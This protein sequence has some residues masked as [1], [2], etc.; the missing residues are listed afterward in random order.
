MFQTT[1]S[2]IVWAKVATNRIWI[3]YSNLKFSEDG[4]KIIIH[5]YEVTGT[6]LIVDAVTGNLF[7]S[8]TYS[9][10]FYNVD[11]EYQ[12]LLLSS[13]YKAFVYSLSKSSFISCG[14]HQLFS[15][16]ANSILSSP[17][18]ALSSKDPSCLS[19]DVT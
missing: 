18:W 12:H 3:S 6:I 1:Q 19:C 14:G 8:R 7:N 15:F 4:A 10:S 16:D 17:T 5:T 9:K 11:S 2:A 13:S